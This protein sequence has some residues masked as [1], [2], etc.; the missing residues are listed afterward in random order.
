MEYDFDDFDITFR[1]EG[2]FIPGESD[3]DVGYLGE[4]E[5]DNVH[6]KL[7]NLNMTPYLT[8][9]AKRRIKE[10]FLDYCEENVGDI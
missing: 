4:G 7:G 5:V 9:S 10:E 3:P 1:I 6:L 8:E 2:E